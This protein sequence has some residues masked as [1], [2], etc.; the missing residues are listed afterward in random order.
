MYPS[1][2]GIKI[3]T[4]MYTFKALREWWRCVPLKSFIFFTALTFHEILG[5]RLHLRQA[6]SMVW[7]HM[8]VLSEFCYVQQHAQ[9][10]EH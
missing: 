1:R 9:R 8:Q 7:W 4:S 6:V 5:L 3:R 2:H 10:L